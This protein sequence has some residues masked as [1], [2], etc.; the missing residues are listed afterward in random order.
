MM[1]SL[2]STGTPT[3]SAPASGITVRLYNTGFGDCILLTFRADDGSP[4]Y[5]LIDCG[6]HHMYPDGDERMQRI[7]SDIAEATGKHLHVVVATHEHTDHLYGFKHGREVFEEFRIDELWL[8]WT[9]DPS[10]PVAQELKRRYGLRIRALAE[11]ADQLRLAGAPLGDV[12]QR[13]L[14]FE[15]PDALAATGGNEAQ[16]EYLRTKSEKKLQGPEDYR[17]PGEA[18][19]T[20][21]GV[22]GVQIYVLGPPR[23]VDWIK[24]L[25]KKSELYPELTAI[26]EAAAF[27]VSALAAAGTDSL[28]KEDRELFRRSCPFDEA[29]EIPEAAAREHPAY[30]S[31][32]RKHYGFSNRKGHGPEWRRVGV[33]WLASAEQLALDVNGKTNNTSLVL[34][35]ELTDSHPG[36]VLL[37]AA[38]AQVG[39][40][41]SWHELS[42]PGKCKDGDA[43]TTAD[44]LRRTVLYKVGHHGSRNATLSEKGLEMM[45]SANLVA[46]IPVDQNWAYETMGWEHP[47]EKLL[48]RLEEKTRGRILRTDRIPSGDEPPEKPEHA[49]EREWQAFIERVDWDRGPERLW[50]QC[51]VSA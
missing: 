18:P 37:F 19:L 50:I 15:F 12:L 23:D 43:V 22:S 40:W 21:S 26:D 47:A 24:K 28:H 42:W 36:K 3:L 9:E 44:L 13:I 41:L 6:V 27:A 38:D 5:M 7:A 32:F 10:D 45:E 1:S 51:T 35:I 14:D 17:R 30:G 16:L 31:F 48:D 20:I 11:A 46:L 2:N 4:R 33:D 29:L 8:A 25:E 49:T 34:A 39:N